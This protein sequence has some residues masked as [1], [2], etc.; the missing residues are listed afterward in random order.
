MLWNLADADEHY[1]ENVIRFPKPPVYFTRPALPATLK[2]RSELGLPDNRRIYMCPMK[3]QKLHPDFDGAM[4]RILE[5][6]NDG[7]ILLFEDCVWPHWKTVLLSRFEGT[8]PA[9]VR[10]RIIF[11]PWLKDPADFISAI[12]AADVVLDPF[13]FGIGSTVAITCATGTPLVTK[14]G[15]FMR[16]RVGAYYCELLGLPECIALDN[17]E[18]VQKAVGIARDPLLRERI[19]AKILKDNS[20]LYEDRQ[21]IEAL[22]EFFNTIAADALLD[23]S[24]HLAGCVL[25][26]KAD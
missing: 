23:A 20:V 17:E 21:A 6:D 12:A 10:E 3:L 26:A 18:Y 24:K 9:E 1:S 2:T 14:A 13:H 5:M 16:G 22:V 8:I 15:E 19:R 11:L 25:P 7:V 4:T